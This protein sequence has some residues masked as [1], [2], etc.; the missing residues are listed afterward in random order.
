[1]DARTSRKTIFFFFL[2]TI[3]YI[4]WYQSKLST[5]SMT[6]KNEQGH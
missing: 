2:P 1:V 5:I 6:S 3:H 4:S